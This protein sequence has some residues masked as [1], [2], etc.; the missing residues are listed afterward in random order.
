MHAWTLSAGTRCEDHAVKTMLCTHAHETHL[1]WCV[2]DG[3]VYMYECTCIWTACVHIRDAHL[4]W[5]VVDAKKGADVLL[6][7]IY[8]SK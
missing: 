1:D 2:V 8:M 6:R 5:C 3:S 4:D 7:V